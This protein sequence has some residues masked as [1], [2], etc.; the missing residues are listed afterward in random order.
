MSRSFRIG[1]VV[2]HE[3]EIHLVES[4][5]GIL[6]VEWTVPQVLRAGYSQG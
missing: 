2:A 3:G 1:K 6:G 5:R 4:C